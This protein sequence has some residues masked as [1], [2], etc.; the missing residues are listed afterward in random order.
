MSLISHCY[1]LSFLREEISENCLHNTVSVTIRWAK[2]S[3]I[4][5]FAGIVEVGPSR[6]LVAAFVSVSS[7]QPVPIC[8]WFHLNYAN[9]THVGGVGWWML[10]PHG[11]AH[12]ITI[13][14]RCNGYSRSS[15]LVNIAT[16]ALQQEDVRPRWPICY[17]VITAISRSRSSVDRP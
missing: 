12:Y 7:I 11:K 8:G 6:R 15:L 17:A 16:Y 4:C 13:E 5:S 3:L 9:T 1:I 10:E 14:T 2:W